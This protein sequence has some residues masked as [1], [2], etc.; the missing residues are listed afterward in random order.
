MFTGSKKKKGGG[1][2]GGLIS[3]RNWKEKDQ[4]RSSREKGKLWGPARKH[5]ARADEHGDCP[6]LKVVKRDF[7]ELPTVQLE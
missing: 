4:S 5:S 2:G 6:Y 1:G 7:G 3:I